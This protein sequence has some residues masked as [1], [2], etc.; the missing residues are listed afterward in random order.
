M[1]E[2]TGVRVGIRGLTGFVFHPYQ[3]DQYGRID[4]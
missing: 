3:P 1:V 4:Q 2:Q